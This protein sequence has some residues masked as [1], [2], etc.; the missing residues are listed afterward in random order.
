MVGVSEK[1]KLIY[2][3]VHRNL[4]GFSSL[5]NYSLM[6]SI[7]EPISFLPMSSSSC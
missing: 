3:Y 5:S 2:H 4:A 1:K 6:K 7:F